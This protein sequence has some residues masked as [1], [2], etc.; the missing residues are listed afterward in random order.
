M[1]CH[2]RAQNSKNVIVFHIGR[3]SHIKEDLAEMIN[4]PAARQSLF[5]TMCEIK[6]FCPTSAVD[7]TGPFNLQE[8]V[9]AKTGSAA[10]SVATCCCSLEK[11]SVDS[12]IF[13]LPTTD[14]QREWRLGP[15]N[16]RESRFAYDQSLA[17]WTIL[18]TEPCSVSSHDVFVRSPS[19]RIKY[20]YIYIYIKCRGILD[21]WRADCALRVFTV[22]MKNILVVRHGSIGLDFIEGPSR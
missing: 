15:Y 3:E 8:S 20:I 7:R 21:W 19:R 4:L 2:T 16:L 1:C 9:T 22:L 14:S 6:S 5:H 11:T 17:L 18:Y 10:E 13:L 12:P